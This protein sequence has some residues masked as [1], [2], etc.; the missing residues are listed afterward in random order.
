MRTLF[1]LLTILALGGASGVYAQSSEHRSSEH[2][3]DKVDRRDSF[4]RREGIDRR[5]RAQELRERRQDRREERIERL[6]ERV[7]SA[8]ANSDGA[9]NREEARRSFPRLHDS[10]DEIDINRDK[11]LDPG[12]IRQYWQKRARERRIERQESDPRY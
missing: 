3:R 9:I 7:H 10:F 11:S 6:R 5:E 2:R 12:E 4:D 8:D 1:F